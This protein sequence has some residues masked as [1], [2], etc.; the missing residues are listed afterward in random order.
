M[1]NR[2]RESKLI[3]PMTTPAFPQTMHEEVAMAP[4]QGPHS[5]G[6]GRLRAARPLEVQILRSQQNCYPAKR[7][8]AV[9]FSRFHADSNALQRPIL[10]GTL[11]ATSNPATDERVPHIPD[12]PW[13]FVDSASFMRLSLSKGAHVDVSRAAYRKFGVSR[14]FCE[15]WE[16]RTS[17]CRLRY[18][19]SHQS[20]HATRGFNLSTLQR[21]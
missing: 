21:S 14:V 4:V 12:F 16:T 19:H 18:S 3:I 10:Q 13:S 1:Q 5:V 9:L 15:M 20:N 11:E 17:T 8:P 6:G 2:N 7:R